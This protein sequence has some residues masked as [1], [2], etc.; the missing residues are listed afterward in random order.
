MP[1]RRAWNWLYGQPYL[2]ATITMAF[3]AANF[4]VGRGVRAD[5]PPVTLALIRWTG[6]FLVLLPFAWP[7]LRA[8]LPVMLR[9]W[10]MMLAL[11]VIGISCFNTFAYTGLQY[12]TAMN[13]LLLQSSAPILIALFVFLIY[14]ERLNLFQALGIAVSLGGVVYIV[15]GGDFALLR[16]LEVNVGDLWVLAGFITWGIYTALLRDRPVIHWLSFLAATFFLGGLALVPFWLWE[17]ASGRVLHFT[18]TALAGGVYV[19]LFPSVIAYMCYNRAVELVGA[20]A[21]GPFFHLIP[22]IGSLMAIVALGER[23]ELFH[24]IGFAVVMAGIALASRRPGGR[25]TGGT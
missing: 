11:S 9:R 23:I 17:I 14:R 20:N 18:W 24:L 19:A 1:L 12:T 21:I 2:L 10:R 6:A 22:V 16:G 7:Y 13:G 15:V 8:D 3:W 5:V 25:W 4:I